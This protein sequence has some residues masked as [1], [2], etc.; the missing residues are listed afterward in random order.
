MALVKQVLGRSWLEHCNKGRR[1]RGLSQTELE[2]VNEHENG[3]WLAGL[4]I[5]I[6]LYGGVNFLRTIGEQYLHSRP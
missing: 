2:D 6:A 5:E 3:F 1:K 4:Y